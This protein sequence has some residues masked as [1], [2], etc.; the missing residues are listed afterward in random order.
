MGGGL[1]DKALFVV[2]AV[3]VL[4]TAFYVFRVVFMTFHGEFRGGADEERRQAE[5][6]LDEKRVAENTAQT[7]VN[8][9]ESPASMVM[10]MLVLAVL[11][12]VIG[13]VANS[14]IDFL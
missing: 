4:M 11:S 13:F 3:T 14:P 2:A 8:L 10:P 6:G 7:G 9:H 5:S 1:I 12:I